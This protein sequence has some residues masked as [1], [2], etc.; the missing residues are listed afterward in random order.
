M[1]K[2]DKTKTRK[3]QIYK[4]AIVLLL[5]FSVS[6]PKVFCSNGNVFYNVNDYGIQSDSTVLITQNING[7]INKVHSN[8]GGTIYFPPGTYL[9][10][11]IKLLSN[12]TIYLEAGT[13]LKFSD[14]FDHYLPMVETRYEG[15]DIK[16]FHPLIYAYKA[17]NIAIVGSGV[18]DG[19]G[20]KWWLEYFHLEEVYPN[21]LSDYQKE[22]L[23]V[24]K[25][26]LMP[27]N[28]L[29]FE[30]GFC[31]PPLFQPMYCE[32]VRLEGVTFQNSPFWTINP[33]FCNNVTI[34]GV[35]V[36]NPDGP[37]TDG[38]NPESCKNVHI[39]DCHISVG[40]DC[41]TIKS[42]KD[43]PGR[44]KAAPA[45]NYTITNCTMLTGHG[46]V[47]IGSEMSG[48]VRNI[49][50]SNCIFDG[51][52]RGIR[53]KS[54]RGRG[55]VVENIRVSN[56]IM[57]DI[58][59]EAVKLNLFYSKT[60][61]EPVSERTPQFRNIHCSNISGNAKQAIAIIGLPEMPV[62]E[63]S[64]TDINIES[65]TGIS[66]SES[67]NISFVHVSVKNKTGEAL[68]IENSS[69][70]EIDG[71]RTNTEHGE[72]PVIQ[73]S[74]VQNA[75]IHS[76]FQTA[77]ANTF[78]KIDGE[79]TKGICFERNYLSNVEIPMSLSKNVPKGAIIKLSDGN[80]K[81]AD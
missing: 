69:I 64:F 9:T 49:V 34:Q 33:E 11:P 60:K 21:E 43:E 50:I 72:S 46:G 29:K 3:S 71:F 26:M 22:F 55:G 20:R 59:L 39:S 57:R 58:R 48:D 79:K 44:T 41:I 27:D 51:T 70:V 32:D 15:V 75:Y 61:P 14:N 80:E 73:L 78:L 62:K 31:R 13:K 7:L 56:I 54:T 12:I 23:K 19:Q 2:T 63:V 10:G 66:V 68:K 67:E 28:P 25:G 16:S 6:L 40:D 47:V 5:L 81:L 52:D 4:V 17:K 18:I 30:F 35:K 38:I 76:S 53:I 77:K 1:I 36:L 8:G 74:N 24:N 42:G 45:E 65:E 37:N